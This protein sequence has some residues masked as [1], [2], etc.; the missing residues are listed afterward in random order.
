MRFIKEK[1][2]TVQRIILLLLFIMI[3]AAII[4]VMSFP[5]E[6]KRSTENFR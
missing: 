1:K 2:R 5:K 6:T 3:G 4:T